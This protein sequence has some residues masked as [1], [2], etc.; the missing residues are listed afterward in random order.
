MIGAQAI[1]VLVEA[2]AHINIEQLLYVAAIGAHAA[3]HIVHLEVGLQEQLLVHNH[4]LHLLCRK[5]AHAWL[6]FRLPLLHIDIDIG[7]LLTI[8]KIAYGKKQRAEHHKGNSQQQGPVGK[9]IP[10]NSIGHKRDHPRYQQQQQDGGDTAQPL[11][12]GSG[13]D[14]VHQPMIGLD[15]AYA[16]PHRE[17][18]TNGKQH[19]AHMMQHGLQKSQ[20]R[21]AVEVIVIEINIEKQRPPQES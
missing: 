17:H 12:V 18:H 14:G 3:C 7:E 16:Q 9:N 1:D 2:H 4:M 19:F 10:P 13:I 11:V 8:A 6:F 20:G 5:I 21:Q 15:L